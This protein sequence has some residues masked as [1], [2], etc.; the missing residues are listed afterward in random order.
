MKNNFQYVNKF[1]DSIIF[2]KIQSRSDV[3][4]SF[5]AHI[6][7]Q[8]AASYEFYNTYDWKTRPVFKSLGDIADLKQRI[9]NVFTIVDV[10]LLLQ[11]TRQKFEDQLDCHWAK[12]VAHEEICLGE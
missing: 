1:V 2:E 3:F 5:M 4:P 11:R 12:I 7:I 10:V 8:A 9:R 6:N